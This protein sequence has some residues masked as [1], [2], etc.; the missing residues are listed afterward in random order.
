MKGSSL[1]KEKKMRTAWTIEKLADWI[2][3]YDEIHKAGTTREPYD[4]EVW[5]LIIQD[6][7]MDYVEGLE[8]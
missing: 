5:K 6:V 3:K 2:S 1:E 4:Y 8:Q 7:A